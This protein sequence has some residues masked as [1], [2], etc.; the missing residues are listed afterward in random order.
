MENDKK[1]L[2]LLLRS[3]AIKRHKLSKSIHIKV[4]KTRLYL[5][6]RV[7]RWKIVSNIKSCVYE[8]HYLQLLHWSDTLPARSTKF[9]SN[10]PTVLSLCTHYIDNCYHRNVDSSICKTLQV[11]WSRSIIRLRQHRVYKVQKIQLNIPNHLHLSSRNKDNLC[12]TI[13][14]W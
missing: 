3:K 8:Y 6:N 7:Y 2:K 4:T 14:N 12:F 10:L 1:F 11:W 5:I 13:F 9:Q